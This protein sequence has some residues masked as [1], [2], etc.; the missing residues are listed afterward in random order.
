M[1][2]SMRRRAS[3]NSGE[4]AKMVCCDGMAPT[5]R[6]V[7]TG[8][9]SLVPSSCRSSKYARGAAILLTAL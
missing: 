6:V 4:S 5:S 2:S 7:E 1:H 9:P 8:S 3:S